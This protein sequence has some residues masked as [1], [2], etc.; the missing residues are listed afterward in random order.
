MK[1]EGGC[2]KREKE[3]SS[4]LQFWKLKEEVI[5]CRFWRRGKTSPENKKRDKLKRKKKRKKRVLKSPE[6]RKETRKP[7]AP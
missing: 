3:S 7:F 4:G 6:T 5:V 2:G 1:N